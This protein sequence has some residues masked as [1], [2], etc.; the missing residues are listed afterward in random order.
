VQLRVWLAAYVAE[1][2]QCFIADVPSIAPAQSPAPYIEALRS[3]FAEQPQNGD[4]AANAASRVPPMP[5][6]QPRTA[7][8]APRLAAVRRITLAHKYAVDRQLGAHAG[9]LAVL[10]A[11]QQTQR[12]SRNASGTPAQAARRVSNAWGAYLEEMDRW[13]MEAAALEGEW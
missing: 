6:E 7:C 1:A 3:A 4:K 13:R 10:L 9:V 11:A 2:Q 5:G 8:L 12:E